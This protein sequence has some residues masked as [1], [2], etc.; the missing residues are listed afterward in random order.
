MDGITWTTF[1]FWAGGM[2][3]IYATLQILALRWRNQ[4]LE[5]YNRKLRSELYGNHVG[6]DNS[7]NNE[8]TEKEGYSKAS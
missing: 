1:F 8:D 5:A 3:V 6:K 4:R 2:A 7:G